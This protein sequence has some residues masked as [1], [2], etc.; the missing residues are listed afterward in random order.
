MFFCSCYLSERLLQVCHIARKK[1]VKQTVCVI[2]GYICIF[3]HSLPIF[4]LVFPISESCITSFTP[5]CRW[6]TGT[7]LDLFLH[8]PCLTTYLVM[9]I[10]K[11]HPWIWP[12][13]ITSTTNILIQAAIISSLEMPV[14]V[15]Q[16]TSLLPLLSY[17][18]S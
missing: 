9:F 10:F 2:F 14:V 13:L 4:L 1:Q 18:I 11:L 7:L 5:F 15:S 12:F 3:W 6:K 16:T 8:Y 17:C